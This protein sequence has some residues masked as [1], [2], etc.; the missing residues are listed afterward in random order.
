MYLYLHRISLVKRFWYSPSCTRIVQLHACL[1][2]WSLFDINN[3]THIQLALS[4]RK[5]GNSI[6]TGLHLRSAGSLRTLLPVLMALKANTML[7]SSE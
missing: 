7:R 2:Q 3:T 6:P 4:C 5:Y 1:W